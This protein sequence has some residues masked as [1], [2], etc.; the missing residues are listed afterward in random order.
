MIQLIWLYRLD[1]L[2]KPSPETLQ[3]N[4]LVDFGHRIRNLTYHQSLTRHNTTKHRLF[5]NVGAWQ[6]ECT[7]Q[8][9]SSKVFL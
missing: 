4:N 5:K 2:S 1:A 7:Q 8:F 9:S 6:G 3:D